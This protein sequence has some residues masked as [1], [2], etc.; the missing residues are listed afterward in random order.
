MKFTLYTEG[1]FS[2]AHHLKDYKGKCANIH[3]HTWKVSVWVKGDENQLNNIGLLWDFNNLNKILHE[4]DHNDLNNIINVNPSVENIAKY[5]YN[6]I[7]QDSPHLDFRV[8]VYESLL[9]KVSYCEL[10]DF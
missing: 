6:K 1:F 3:G 10:G 9:K 7:K 8:R 5:I 4:L 2:A